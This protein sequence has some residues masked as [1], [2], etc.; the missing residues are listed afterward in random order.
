MYEERDG[1][2]CQVNIEGNH[3][4][5]VDVGRA[6]EKVSIRDS[7][8]IKTERRKKMRKKNTG[9]AGAIA[10]LFPHFSKDSQPDDLAEIVEDL[11]EKIKEEVEEKTEVPDVK[12]PDAALTAG[13]DSVGDGG[14]YAKVYEV[15]EKICEKLDEVC[16][17]VEALEASYK[18]D[19]DPLEK[20][21]EELT[22]D[23]YEEEEVT[24]DPEAINEQSDDYAVVEA[25]EIIE[26][27]AGP[28]MPESGKPENPLDS[29]S[30]KDAALKEIRKMKPIVAGIKDAK[31]RKTLSDSLAGMIRD[32]YSLPRNRQNGGGGY[33]GIVNARANNARHH[34]DSQLQNTS[35]NNFSPERYADLM[36]KM[37]KRRTDKN[38][39]HEV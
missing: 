27:K 32:A 7:N 8:P 35:P 12:V 19:K 18:T 31:Q 39:K 25:E 9:I 22:S 29:K 5:V 33:G 11:V 28:V 38:F 3:I 4:A 2:I 15:L 34:Y 16:K 24:S 21:E 20:L 37:E 23:G 30:V 10:N 14:D 6:G 17:K 26:D 13:G 36:A 1:R